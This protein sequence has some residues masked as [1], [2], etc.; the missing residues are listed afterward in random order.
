[1]FT[2][3]EFGRRNPESDSAGKI[4]ITHLPYAPELQPDDIGDHIRGKVRWYLQRLNNT[5]PGGKQ[6]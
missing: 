6:S 3:Y 5:L 4:D 2:H 1:V